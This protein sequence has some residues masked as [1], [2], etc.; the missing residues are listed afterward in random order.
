[1]SE[2]LKYVSKDAY[3]E[4]KQRM[5]DA[6]TEYEEKTQILTPSGK[7]RSFSKW[8]DIDIKY[9]EELDYLKENTI[10]DDLFDS[11][12]KI[13]N[14]SMVFWSDELN[15]DKN[16]D[17]WVLLKR[18]KYLKAKEYFE[19]ITYEEKNSTV[20]DTKVE[21]HLQSECSEEDEEDLKSEKTK[22]ED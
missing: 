22:K 3:N 7:I 14:D 21:D 17:V 13:D 19:S 11:D 20:E 8:K 18:V 9:K 10:Y 4:A 1:M 6:L 2:K 16:K 15:V 12:G 5:K